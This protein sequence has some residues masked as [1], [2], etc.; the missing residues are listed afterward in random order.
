MF[1]NKTATLSSLFYL[2]KIFNSLR[3]FCE[4]YHDCTISLNGIN[5]NEPWPGC[6]G[7]GLWILCSCT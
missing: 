5:L 1:V 4:C 6:Q 7:D 3:T 2:P